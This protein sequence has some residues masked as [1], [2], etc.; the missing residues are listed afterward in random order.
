MWGKQQ[1]QKLLGVFGGFSVL[2]LQASY[3][4]IMRYVSSFWGVDPDTA[5]QTQ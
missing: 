2:V 5:M 1:S 4:M 3:E